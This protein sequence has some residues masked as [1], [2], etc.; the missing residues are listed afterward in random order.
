MVPQ[1][2]RGESAVYDLLC[3]VLRRLGAVHSDIIISPGWVRYDTP[4]VHI[5]QYN[6]QKKINRIFLDIAI[7]K[8]QA[9]WYFN[10]VQYKGHQMHD[11]KQNFITYHTCNKGVVVFD[12]WKTRRFFCILKGGFYYEIKGHRTYQGAAEGKSK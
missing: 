1:P 8:T 2:G 10:G 11:I 9:S 5:V 6:A 4:R 12:F 7:D 3:G